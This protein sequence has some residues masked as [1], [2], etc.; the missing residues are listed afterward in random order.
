[1]LKTISIII[2]FKKIYDPS[3]NS[4]AMK[5]VPREV[6]NHVNTIDTHINYSV[7]NY[8]TVIKYVVNTLENIYL[9]NIFY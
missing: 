8:N 4:E 3:K 7:M 6:E 9:S 1:M 2:P 5:N